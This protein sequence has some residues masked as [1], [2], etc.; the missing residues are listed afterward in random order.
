M[1][2]LNENQ[3]LFTNPEPWEKWEGKL[4]AYS[5][6]TGIAGLVVLGILIN[7]LIL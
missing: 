7:W 4:V 6:L 5:I 1:S 3:S 2:E